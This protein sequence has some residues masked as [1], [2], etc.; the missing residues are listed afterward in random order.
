M[1][2]KHS[3]AGEKKRS[4]YTTDENDHK[5]YTSAGFP[6]VDGDDFGAMVWMG[7]CALGVMLLMWPQA[8][9]FPTQS[10]LGTHLWNPI[11]IAN[12]DRFVIG[13]VSG[14]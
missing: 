5:I 9:P 1:G 13:R 3:A 11:L 6:L 2:I 10:V 7:T 8:V 4:Q 12:N 14:F